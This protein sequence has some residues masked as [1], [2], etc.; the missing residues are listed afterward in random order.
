MLAVTRDLLIL[1]MEYFS[2]VENYLFLYIPQED[3][4]ESLSGEARRNGHTFMTTRDDAGRSFILPRYTTSS[5]PWLEV[6]VGE[7]LN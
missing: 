1:V 3:E 2:T 4:E 7:L 6:D 5:V